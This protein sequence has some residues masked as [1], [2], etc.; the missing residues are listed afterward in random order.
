MK[1]LSA[2]VGELSSE[3]RRIS[4]ELHPAKL[5]QLGLVAAMRGVCNE[6]A[7]AHDISIDFE[8]ADIPSSIPDP[9]AL[10]LYRIGQEALQNVV[11]HSGHHKARV[12]IGMNG[13][14]L[15]L[16]ISDDGRGFDARKAAVNGSLGLVGMRERVRFLGGKI[17]I[18]SHP[19]EGTLVEATVPI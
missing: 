16:S 2:R 8:D 6:L 10:C 12:E 9:A 1:R 14:G 7:A 13:E 15:R 5:E 11:K 18:A 19:G 3:L 4:H 17:S